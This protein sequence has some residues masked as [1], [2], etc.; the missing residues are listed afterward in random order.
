MLRTTALAQTHQAQNNDLGLMKE[1]RLDILNL[2]G[3]KIILFHF[4]KKLLKTP[5]DFSNDF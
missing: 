5:P 2:S 3:G 4:W 1:N